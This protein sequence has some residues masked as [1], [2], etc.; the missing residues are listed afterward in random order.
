VRGRE[1]RPTFNVFETAHGD[2]EC[3]TF[4]YILDIGID[5]NNQCSFGVFVKHADYEPK[6]VALH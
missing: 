2:V 1:I 5:S 6:A 3:F 4:R